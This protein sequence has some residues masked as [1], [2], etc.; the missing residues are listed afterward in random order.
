MNEQH[1]RK[2]TRFVFRTQL[3]PSGWLIVKIVFIGY[4]TLV[5]GLALP[6]TLVV[7]IAGARSSDWMFLPII[8]LIVPA[9]GALL[10]VV[11]NIGLWIFSKYRPLYVEVDAVDP[12][13]SN[14][15]KVGAA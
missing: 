1:S 6:L 4:T 9:Q 7:A 3:T 14:R 13:G 8:L 15:E 2:R 5:L 12:W 11:V 10:G